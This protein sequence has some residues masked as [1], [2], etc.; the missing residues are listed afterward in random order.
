MYFLLVTVLNLSDA[1]CPPDQPI[2]AT[3]G[4]VYHLPGGS[5]Y[6]KVYPRHCFAKPKDAEDAGYKP[7]TR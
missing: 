5:Y 4:G 7:S 2:K 1:K 3:A 6:D